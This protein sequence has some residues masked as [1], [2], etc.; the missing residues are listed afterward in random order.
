[1][2]KRRRH[3]LPHMT[4]CH[5]K[6]KSK[7]KT[8]CRKKRLIAT[9]S[10]TTK[11]R[12]CWPK[13]L[14]L[15]RWKIREPKGE[16]SLERIVT[17]RRIAAL[18]LVVPTNKPAT[19]DL[20]GADGEIVEHPGP[21]PKN[22]HWI[23]PWASLRRDLSLKL[24]PKNSETHTR[25]V[26]KDFECCGER[27]TTRP[28]RFPGKNCFTAAITISFIAGRKHRTPGKRRSQNRSQAIIPHALHRRHG[29]AGHRSAAA[30]A[31][32]SRRAGR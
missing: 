29:A 7:S 18:K 2:L 12:T 14:A 11:N 24:M 19:Q 3:Q 22:L 31:G 1:M 21:E 10:P 30:F 6:A 26:D 27:I 13:W 28:R 9:N 16:R 15:N 23:D 5:P 4:N 25:A 20:A 8:T 17:R 32:R